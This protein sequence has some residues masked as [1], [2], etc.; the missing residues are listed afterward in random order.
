MRLNSVKKIEK[1]LFKQTHDDALDA[2]FVRVD[3]FLNKN[4]FNH[5]DVTWN[6]Q[7][8]L[9]ELHELTEAIDQLMSDLHDGNLCEESIH[10]VIEELGDWILVSAT[11][12][13]ESGSVDSVMKEIEF[14]RSC[15]N[16][17]IS[18][19]S[20]YTK[21]KINVHSVFESNMNKLRDYAQAVYVYKNV[22]DDDFV[23][24]N[25]LGK[26]MRS[27]YT[28]KELASELNK[29]KIIKELRRMIYALRVK[30]VD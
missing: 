25:S 5:K 27:L 30:G 3:N 15:I 9:E 6:K 14:V 12:V 28:K 8:M 24:F 11:I 16:D 26:M 4:Y 22:M 7:K 17:T 10:H 23:I 1:L 29:D 21:N 2:S 13:Q 20:E 19:T 18:R